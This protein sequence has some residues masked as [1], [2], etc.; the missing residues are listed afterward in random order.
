MEFSAQQASMFTYLIEILCFFIRQHHHRS[1]FFVLQNDIVTRVGQLLGC[2]EKFLKLGMSP[3]T[4]VLN[5]L[6]T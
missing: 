2:P 1:K 3:R 5:I 6:L 4:Y